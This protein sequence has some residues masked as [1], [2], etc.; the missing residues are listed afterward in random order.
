ME[1]TE[2]VPPSI[3]TASYI[4]RLLF[5]RTAPSPSP[6]SFSFCL[7]K[8]ITHAKEKV[9]RNNI[10][11]LFKS[12]YPLLFPQFKFYLKRPIDTLLTQRDKK[13]RR[14]IPSPVSERGPFSPRVILYPSPTTLRAEQKRGGRDWMS[15]T[16]LRLSHQMVRRKG[17][18]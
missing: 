12:L 3:R 10:D 5:Q 18:L 6:I 17:H 2:R 9:K 14:K 16:L 13:K 1:G 8:T 4:L 7:R 15:P 11:F